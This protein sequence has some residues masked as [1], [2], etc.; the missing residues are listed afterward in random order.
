MTEQLRKPFE[1]FVD[2]RQCVAVMQGEE[3]KFIKNQQ[4]NMRG[5]KDFKKGVLSIV[6][7][8]VFTVMFQFEILWVVTPSSLPQHYTASQPTRPRLLLLL[9]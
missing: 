3:I 5:P 9:R 7:F 8:E 1:K 4:A 2:W 6:K